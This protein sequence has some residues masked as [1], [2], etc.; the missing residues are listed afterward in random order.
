MVVEQE[1]QMIMSDIVWGDSDQT[2]IESDYA[3]CTN[4]TE[5]VNNIFILS[6]LLW[7]NSKTLK[8]RSK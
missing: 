3:I 8:K 7:E 4:S 1:S 5:M 6:N 2:S